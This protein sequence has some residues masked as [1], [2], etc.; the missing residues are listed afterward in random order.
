MTRIIIVL[1][2]V[3]FTAASAMAGTAT[4]QYA[5]PA[6]TVAGTPLTNLKET[7]I[8][9]KQ[10]NGVEQAIKVPAVTATGNNQ[11]SRGVSFTDPALC[12]STTVTVAVTASNTSNVESARTS[13]VSVTT[14]NS[15]PGCAV[16]NSPTNLR[17]TI[18]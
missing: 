16:P 6:V 10:D 1:I 13:P 3:L 17:V 8:Y 15:S 2:A 5:E 9:W 4:V 14:T 12:A 11:I 7:T 18:P